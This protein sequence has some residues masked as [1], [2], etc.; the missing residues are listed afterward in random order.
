MTE[1]VTKIVR[2]KETRRA[3]EAGGESAGAYNTVN[4]MYVQEKF[5]AAQG[6][7]FAAERANDLHDQVHGKQVHKGLGDDNAKDGP[8]RMVN[9]KWIQSKYYADGKRAIDACFRDGGKGTL[10]Y[11]DQNNEPMRIEVPSDDMIYNKAVARMQEKIL[12]GQVKGVS[13]PAKA[14]EIVQKGNYT[15]KQARNIAKA[16]NI[17]S[18]KFDATNGAITAA[19]AFGVSAVI[20]F[21]TSIWQGDSPKVAAKNAAFCGLKVG[22]TSFVVAVLSGQLLKAGLNSAMVAST[23]AIAAQLGP[24][25][26]A[27]I[28]NAFRSGAPIYGAAAMRSTAKLLR[29]N[30]VVAGLTVVVCSTFDVADIV[31]GRISATQLAKNLSITLT[32]V[33]GGSAGW[34]GGAALG[35]LVA[36][37][38]GSMIGGVI[39]SMS[40][41][42]AAGFVTDK[43]ASIFLKSDAEEMQ[44][45][46]EKI[47]LEIQA[48]YLLSEDETKHFVESLSERLNG[49]V[50]KD[51]FASKDR[52][53]FAEG[54]AIP[55][56]ETEVSKRRQIKGNIDDVIEEGLV[57]AL[58]EIAE[59]EQ[60][61]ND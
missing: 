39:G 37:G 40:A 24:K 26:C 6:H 27:V 19:S 20:A 11:V 35:T 17:D 15:Y 47:A 60:V 23:E 25:T 45:I 42:T 18:L 46:V 29:G 3:A 32:S 30:I 53:K 36:P 22:G 28:A 41:G 61:D 55:L 57:E 43:V 1:D 31:R 59:G 14:S 44:T 54:L 52:E 48:D 21:G 33:A 13:D 5:H 2:K 16:G 4:Q 9:G 12:N 10:R 51:M 7:D 8:D 49:K 50:L 58:K 56:A 38:I 34:V